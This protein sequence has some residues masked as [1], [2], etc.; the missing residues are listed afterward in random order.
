M[1]AEQTL[2]LAD[3]LMRQAPNITIGFVDG[4]VKSKINKTLNW[5]S[6]KTGDE[7]GNIVKFCIKQGR[8][9]KAL[10]QSHEEYVAKMQDERLIEKNQ[11]KDSR[12]RKT[13]QKKLNSVAE[14][15]SELSVEFVDLTDDQMKT[16]LEVLANPCT[17]NGLY[18]EHL[19]FVN[20]QNVM[21][22]GHV[23]NVKCS[24]KSTTPKV[25]VTYWK[26]EE[27]EEEG[28]DVTM[29]LIEF[30]VDCINGDLQI[31]E[32]ATF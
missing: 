10:C 30:L 24:K 9:S 4:K 11:K 25:T 3:H 1:F 17:I 21:Y 5:L 7:Q 32:P 28:E 31:N 16:I 14:G 2:G 20:Q 15:R 12:F 18:C 23:I 22:K 13:L 29:T 27:T 26:Y 6:N 19:W 8:K